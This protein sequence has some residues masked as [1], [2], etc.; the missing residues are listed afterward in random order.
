[1]PE[2]EFLTTDAVGYGGTVQKIPVA[3]INHTTKTVLA[4]HGYCG[5]NP[6]NYK[7][8]ARAKAL[9]YKYEE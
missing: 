9:G 7:I 3:L 1:M 2:T 8:R 5:K 4:C 6:H